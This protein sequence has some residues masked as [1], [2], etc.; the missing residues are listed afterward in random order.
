MPDRNLIYSKFPKW[1]AAL[2]RIS[3]KVGPARVLFLGDST[4]EG[5]F[6]PFQANL[7]Q[8]MLSLN[9]AASD[10]AIWGT[11]TYGTDIRIVQGTGWGP[12]VSNGWGPYTGV[13]WT[14]PTSATGNLQFTFPG[15]IDTITVY[16]A[17]NTGYGTF[18]VNVDGGPS[19]G[20]VVTNQTGQQAAK[21]TFTC[22]P[23][24]HTIN[25][26]PPT[27]GP[28]FILGVEAYLSTAP[29]ILYSNGGSTGVITSFFANTANPWTTLHEFEVFQPDLTIISTGIN[30]CRIGGTDLNAMQT[31]LTQIVQKAQIYG[32]ILICSMIPSASGDGTWPR[33][34]TE[35]PMFESVAV[36]NNCGYYDLT[37]PGRFVDWN[38]ANAHG[39]MGDIYHPSSAGYAFWASLLNAMLLSISGTLHTFT[40]QWQRA[41]NVAFT[42]GVASIPGATSSNYTTTS[43]EGTKFVRLQV[44]ATN[45]IS[46][47]SNTTSSNILGPFGVTDL[48]NANST[49]SASMRARRRVAANQI[50][51][52]CSLSAVVTDAN[53][54]SIQG[55]I[56]AV[57]TVQS[58]VTFRIGLGAYGANL[59][60][61]GLYGSGEA[62]GQYGAGLYGAGL[63][64]GL[65][66]A[67]G[68]GTYGS[69]LYGIGAG[70]YG[71]GTYGAGPYGTGGTAYSITTGQITAT[72]SMSASLQR[73]PAIPSSQISATSSVSLTSLTRRTKIIGSIAAPS[74]VAASITAIRRLQQGQ[75]FAT[76]IVSANIV[77]SP[78]ILPSTITATSSVSS[79]I[80]AS[81]KIVAS[82]ISATSTISA[83]VFRIGKL[84]PSQINATSTASA[85]LTV[86]PAL[87]IAGQ[88]FATSTVSGRILRTANLFGLISATST[89]SAG[90]RVARRIAP[91]QINATSTVTGQTFKGFVVLPSGISALSSVAIVRLALKRNLLGAIVIAQTSVSSLRF[92]FQF[93]GAIFATSTLSA[94]V[95]GHI[96]LLPPYRTGIIARPTGGSIRK[97]NVGVSV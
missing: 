78:K 48:I 54:S 15:S 93:R 68:A 33:E 12:W 18:T 74:T 9:P 83:I 40:Y 49:V 47:L 58:G 96:D 97:S 46:G 53:L 92:A 2:E 82:P 19:L 71:A 23:G 77:R 64:G 25:I 30:D 6:G 73:A 88:V 3:N 4:M 81:R 91:L 29:K 31:A 39:W 87:H 66:G 20:T 52:T 13:Q 35:M 63:Y 79:R 94:H 65:A 76:S 42:V 27:V 36:T 14:A 37:L 26:S 21:T 16:Y 69:G 11:T 61:K 32:D 85:T 24:H 45:T 62:A 51:A 95:I 57:A 43:T 28:I 80:T 1:N 72:S 34:Q 75:I 17:R 10:G 84:F 67:Y 56:N 5:A 22:A 59:Y 60:G 70:A 7:V 90:M 50:S 86:L 89:V 38:N 41:N 8:Q 55:Q 44:T